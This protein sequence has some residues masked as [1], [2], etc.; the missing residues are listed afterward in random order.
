MLTETILNNIAIGKSDNLVL[1]TV[2]ICV[3][4]DSC[5]DLENEFSLH[6]LVYEEENSLA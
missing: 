5:F 6:L 3:P 2:H 4:V 1:L